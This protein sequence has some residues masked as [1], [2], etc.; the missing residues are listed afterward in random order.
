MWETIQVLYSAYRAHKLA[1][2]GI[3]SGY[4]ALTVN[5]VPQVACY[6]AVGREAWRVTQIAIEGFPG[7][8]RWV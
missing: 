1:K 8:N 4:S 7:G 3:G 2:L 6:V 5:G